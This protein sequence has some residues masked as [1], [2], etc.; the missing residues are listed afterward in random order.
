MLN[1]FLLGLGILCSAFLSAQSSFDASGYTASSNSVEVSYSLGQIAYREIEGN[2][3]SITPGVQQPYQVVILSATPTDDHRVCIFPNPATDELYLKFDHF[4]E[5]A[6]A[7]LFNA[8]GKRISDLLITTKTTRIPLHNLSGGVYILSIS[9]NRKTQ[10]TF[11]V[12]VK[13]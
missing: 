4:T 11:K 9:M 7:T 10:Q 1:I 13:S 3:V 6:T 12:I 8:Q 5:P 2:D